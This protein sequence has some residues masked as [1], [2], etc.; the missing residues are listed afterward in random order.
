MTTLLASRQLSISTVDALLELAFSKFAGSQ[1]VQ[2][3]FPEA[4]EGL[5][6]LS[7]RSNDSVLVIRLL[8]EVK[9]SLN[10]ESMKVLW[11]Q[12]WL[13]WIQPLLLSHNDEV[14]SVV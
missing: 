10:A 12:P 6:D 14:R 8:Q 9:K 1:E 3:V 4:I 2:L 13:D 11:E 7:Q 5:L